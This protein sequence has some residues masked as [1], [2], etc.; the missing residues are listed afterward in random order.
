VFRPVTG[1]CWRY[2]ECYSACEQEAA[3]AKAQIQAALPPQTVPAPPAPKPA[4][5]AKAAMNFVPEER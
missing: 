5:A 3:A 2:G 1:N 4:K